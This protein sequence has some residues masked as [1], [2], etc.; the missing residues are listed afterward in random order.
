MRITRKSFISLATAG[1]TG[2]LLSTSRAN[3]GQAKSTK[4]EKAA[5]KGTTDALT[6]FIM[7]AELR[8]MPADVVAQA[9]RCLVDGFGVILAGSTVKGS[10]IV[11]DYVRTVSDRKEATSVGAGTL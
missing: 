8:S 6:A 2:A 7:K 5:I 1:A 4:S 9:K 11:R 10:E 3:A